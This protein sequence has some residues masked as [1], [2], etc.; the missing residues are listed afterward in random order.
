MQAFLQQVA[1][2]IRSYGEDFADICVVLPNRRAGLFLKKYLAEDLDKPVFAP[3]IFSIEDF[4][5]KIS[6]MKT[7][8]AAGLLFELYETHRIIE[9]DRAQPFGE[10]VRWGQMLLSDFGEIDAWM[11]NAS[12][13]FGYLNEVKA[14]EKWSPGNSLTEREKAYLAFYR[15]LL[16]YYHLLKERLLKK[17]TAYGGMISRQ[18]AENP[19][20]LHDLHW[21]KILFAGFNA[22]TKAEKI[23][24][25][26]LVEQKKAELFWDADKYYIP[27]ERQEAGLF[28]RKHFSKTAREKFKWLNDH[29]ETSK[30]EIK[31]I[32]VPKNVSQARLA[33]KTILKWI[34][35]T[36]K[37]EDS[38]IS[39]T[40]TFEN[41]ALVLADENLLMPVLNSLPGKLQAFNVTMGF[42]LQQT[43]AYGLLIQVIRLYENSLRFGRVER[44]QENNFYYSDLLKLLQQPLFSDLAD[45]AGMISHINRSNRIFYS[46]TQIIALDKEHEDIFR[47]IFGIKE[48]SPENILMVLEKLTG[49]IARKIYGEITEQEN[50]YRETELEYL[51]HFS[52]IITRIDE[53]LKQYR[54]ITEVGTLRE[55]FKNVASMTKVPFSGEPLKGLQVM[56][57]LE[58]R[59]LDF[60]RL[61]LLSVNEG[62]LPTQGFGNSFIPFDIQKQFGLP[63]YLEKNAVFAYHFYRLLQRAS[64]IYLIYNTESD[65]LGGGEMSRFIRQLINEMPG[66]NQKVKITESV[67][68]LT[69][70]DHKKEI[71]RSVDKDGTVWK[72]LL[73]KAEK[74][75]AP[76][77]INSYRRC[78]LQFYLQEIAALEENEE[79]EETLDYRTIGNIVH[80][81]LNYL[82][83]PYTGKTLSV[84]HIEEMEKKLESQ[85]EKS[86]ENKYRE[87]E[88]KFGKNRLIYE[89]IRKFVGD[90]L[91]FE[92]DFIKSL[93]KTA[94]KLTIKE[95]EKKVSYTYPL[96]D[97]NIEVVLKGFVDRVDAVDG[98]IR[99][100]DYK[101]GRVEKS[102]LN[103]SDWED[104]EDGS[105]LEKA[106]QV[107]MYAWLYQ[108]NSGIE[109]PVLEAGVISLR[110]L[111]N[112][113][114][115]F[116]VKSDHNPTKN[117][118]IDNGLLNDFE[119]VLEQILGEIFDREIPFSQTEDREICK[120]CNFKGICSRD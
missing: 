80:D 86:F 114:I 63:T 70:P 77:A 4:F 35:E 78:P 29:L 19:D 23:V 14:I 59:N 28:I 46:L 112:G 71:T 16:D 15:S 34:N 91:R 55:I 9:K 25:D 1:G 17:K 56:G 52:K 101:T 72:K 61:I 53:L 62:I 94:K 90:Y 76:S 106:F 68:S 27:D 3:D 21:K 41:T 73:L 50:K 75:L 100:I 48:F 69:P 33:G 92:K 116:G 38:G 85:L 58:T 88:I 11:V 119:T 22:L 18:V 8:D 10:F 12:E 54:V 96:P 118:L 26:R 102:D 98:Q 79:V 99:I 40:D 64:E 97:Q 115:T 7:T 81:A 24:I 37:N 66:K 20:L 109:N 67:E 84:A 120:L 65:S 42:P 89:V 39:R 44:T 36:N 51:F 82:F 31:I 113:F 47:L 60:E 5:V 93:I 87:G 111:S 108:K 45:T 83:E 30:K 13:L 107:L 43:N 2:E 105:K 6:G 110:K 74:G 104:F 32:G 103:I 95:L 57:M 49:L 117:S